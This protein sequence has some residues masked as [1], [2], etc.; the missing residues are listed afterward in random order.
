MF[1]EVNKTQLSHLGEVVHVVLFEVAF[2]HLDL[3]CLK[4]ELSELS[5]HHLKPYLLNGLDLDYASK[6]QV[7]LY[8]QDLTQTPHKFSLLQCVSGIET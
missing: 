1:R 4:S 7:F 5:S 3:Y 6:I 2:P 8:A